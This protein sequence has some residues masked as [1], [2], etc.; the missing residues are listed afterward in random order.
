MKASRFCWLFS[1]VLSAL[2]LSCGSTEDNVYKSESSYD[3]SQPPN[4]SYDAYSA[5]DGV[6]DT[7]SE[8]DAVPDAIED[9]S[10]PPL[11]E[12]AWFQLS[13]DDSTSMASAQ[14]LKLEYFYGMSL[15]THE[16][17]NYYDPPETMRNELARH[18]GSADDIFIGIDGERLDEQRM[19]LLIHVY[20]PQV[21]VQERRPWNLHLCVDVSGSMSGERID[22]TKD[23]LH[24]LVAAMRDGDQLSLSTFESNGHL[25]L[26]PTP[27]ATGRATIN[28]AING[29]DAQGS[30][31]MKA[32]LDIAYE[33]AKAAYDADMVN[34]VL[35]FSDGDANVGETDYATIAQLTRMNKLE[36]IYLSG[37]G[38]GQD[39]AMGRMDALTDA[40]KGAHVF[41]PN[42]DE[43]GVVFGPMLRKMIEVHADEIAVEL[44][45]PKGFEIEQFSGE[46]VSTNPEQR[47]QNIVLAAGDDLS[48]LAT[49]SAEDVALF[50]GELILTFKYRPLSSGQ[51]TVF[52]QR[53][54]IA[55]VLSEQPTLL[56]QRTRLVNEYAKWAMEQSELD[57]DTLLGAV[58][59]FLPQ[60]DGLREI[61]VQI[62]RLR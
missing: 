46:E 18:W 45:L 49:F 37:V 6:Q 4:Q 32:G 9:S 62:A 48:M 55:D 8:P 51:F 53:L 5:N 23:A 29:L 42:A 56:L 44:Q 40:G 20:A 38:V 13:P 58:Q 54:A 36:G 1:I 14:L 7:A 43:V 24:R 10:E 52:E 60:D 28:A 33:Q 12:W 35:L 30:T 3:S 15:H 21:L 17:I 2:L 57:A 50:D 11:E 19:E 16:V 34:R 47:L 25:V 27:V 41:L 59:G 61:A 39:Y 31:N 26:P 22:F